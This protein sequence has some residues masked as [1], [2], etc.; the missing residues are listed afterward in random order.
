MSSLKP[1]VA[2][3]EGHIASVGGLMNLNTGL[4]RPRFTLLIEA[5]MNEDPFYVAMHQLFC[6]WDI[7]RKQITSIPGFP[8]RQQLSSAFKIL[9]QLIRDNEQLAPNHK[10]WFS[11]FP[12]PL[13][14]LLRTS[15]PYRR[16]VKDVGLFLG[17]L[18]T[19]WALLS[20]D[21]KMR[22]YPPLV[23]ELVSRMGLLSPILQGVVFTA[24]RRNLGIRD[25][26]VGTM[27]E[28]LFKKDQYEHQELAARY[29]TNRPPTAKEI[30]ERNA[31]LANQYLAL[32]N[33]LI[34]RRVSMAGGSLPRLPTPVVPSNSH[35]LAG[36]PTPTATHPSQVINQ[37]AWHHLAPSPD[38][39]GNWQFVSQQS[40]APPRTMARSPNPTNV[41]GRP[42]SVGAQRVFTNTPS[43][44]LL[45]GLSMH[46]PGQQESHFTPVVR[47][48]SGHAQVMQ[49]GYVGPTGMFY[50]NPV[51][52]V[53]QSLQ[54]QAQMHQ[55]RQQHLAAQQN[56][57]HQF[58]VQQQQLTNQQ[59]AQQHQNAVIQ[60]QQ[61]L[62]QQVVNLNRAAQ[63]R[64]DSNG[65]IQ[66]QQRAHSRNNSISSSGRRTP[67]INPLAVQSPR[68]FSAS[69]PGGPRRP[70]PETN[71]QIIQAKIQSYAHTPP[72]QRPLIPPL[73]FPHPIQ[74]LN[75][76]MTALHQAHIRSPILLAVDSLP[77]DMAQDEPAS[78]F[79]QAVRG[80]IFDP[81][82]ISPNTPLSKFE[83]TVP[84][85]DLPLLPNDILSRNGQPPT[86]P[87]RRDGGTLQ[88]RL[89]CVQMK[90]LETK[91]PLS[92]WVVHD[93][94][95]P[96]STSLDINQHHLEIRRKNHHGK[97]LPVDITP[98]VRRSGPNLGNRITMSIIKGRSKMK[99]FSYFLGVE[100]IEILQ[101]T[102][103]LDMCYHRRIPADYILNNIKKS[104][105]GSPD[106]DDDLA[107]VVSDL[108]I[109]LA[110]PFTA[111]IFEVPVRG[112]SCLHR[113]CFD[114]ET[115][116]ITRT[117]K[118]KR[119]YQPSMIDVWKCPLCGGDARPYTLQIDD[120][121][122]SVR[123][124]L[125]AQDRLDAKAIWVSADGNWR[126][127]EEPLSTSANGKRSHPYDS[128]D[129]SDDEGA[130]K[131]S[132]LAASNQAKPKKVVEVIDLDDD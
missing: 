55:Q 108:S 7:D 6:V 9:G 99:E 3:I 116:L 72:L 37:T 83:F 101:H 38:P 57:W 27:M 28:D 36:V 2:A 45:Q 67:I 130:R 115:W 118:V 85:S 19:D 103:I 117:S 97:D 80:F 23:D 61:Y 123:A 11:N 68:Q 30:E 110:D 50:Q 13:P 82:K 63:I 41:P 56:Q 47:S 107:M 69:I 33:Q 21:C 8:D 96:E 24:T 60:Q 91:C 95:W 93:T 29:N 15:E 105:A 70:L 39:S 100:V 54:Q 48:N 114:L 127:K 124:T 64:R 87:F 58:P 92:E 98:F 81:K 78:R 34:Q 12:K 94:V 22:G 90:R 10:G 14:D 46:S 1:R 71:D 44:T 84:V 113:E 121:L 66:V 86:R 40:Q 76:D 106:N 89:R 111:R 102:Q 20:N 43:P 26:E 109:D 79:Y 75:A 119:Q 17:R 16:I 126:V 77:S 31:T 131:P 120:F 5:C 59:A 62:S 49:T 129:S 65:G 128:D 112:S 25:E 42:P 18:A 122:A 53:D 104:L 4:E 51:Q 74:P 125:A 35:Q 52:N 73:A 132:I 88:Y 32:H